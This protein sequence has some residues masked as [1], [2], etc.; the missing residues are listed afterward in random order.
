MACHPLPSYVTHPSLYLPSMGDQG[1]IPYK[2]T[3]LMV[4]ENEG[5]YDVLDLADPV[6]CS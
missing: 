1:V 5:E 3:L 2:N 4:N 6:V